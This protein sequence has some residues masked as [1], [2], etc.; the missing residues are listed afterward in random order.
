MAHKILFFLFLIFSTFQVLK[1]QEDAIYDDFIGVAQPSEIQLRWVILGGQTCNGTFIERSSDTINWYLVGDIQ[2]VC[3]SSS[4]P[5]AYNFIDDAPLSNAINY[6][7]L[8]LGGR[9]YSNIIKVP[10]YDFDSRG[11]VLFPN[12]ASEQTSLFFQ[13][14]DNEPYLIKL[15][16]SR[17]LPVKEISGKGNDCSIV[18]SDLA[19]GNYV[20]NIIRKNKKNVSGQLIIR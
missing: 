4:A 20:F 3:G 15:T 1:A 13:N 10:Y 17:G 12:P 14:S 16:D 19:A 6:Y 5:V 11:Y 2:G 8:E 18:L 7:R 9:G